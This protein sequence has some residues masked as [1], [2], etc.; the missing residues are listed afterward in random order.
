M[1][2]TTITFFDFAIHEPVTALTDFIITFL[3]LF[4]FFQLRNKG[5]NVAINWWKA[6]FMLFGLS[7]F[8]GGF[9][10][11][12]FIIH[13]GMEYKSCWISMQVLNGFAV[14]S[15]QMATYHTVLQN[16][17][18]REWWKQS[19]IVQLF[20]FLAAVI[21]Y[22]DFLVVVLN[23]VVGLVPVI[24]LHFIDSKKSEESKLI[25]NGILISFLTGI[26]HGAKL[27]LHAYFN[28]NDISHVLIMLSLFVVFSG[29]SVKMIQQPEL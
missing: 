28:F 25:A 11:A 13:Q 10:H 8:F 12:L 3:C 23:N 21:F 18:S 7:A 29:V 9:S 17:N 5:N 2:D 27:S 14:F 4:F 24:A 20:I 6:F 22:Q 19:Y 26:V 16:T 15:V 1:T